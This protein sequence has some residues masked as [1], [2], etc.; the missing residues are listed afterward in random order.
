MLTSDNNDNKNPS[1]EFNQTRPRSLRSSG[2]ELDA[3]CPEILNASAGTMGYDRAMKTLGG[4]ASDI[5]QAEGGLG[6][7]RN[8]RGMSVKGEQEKAR[9]SGKFYQPARFTTVNH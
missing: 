9:K 8:L 1:K 3:V 4:K 2:T 7:E 5:P 6:V